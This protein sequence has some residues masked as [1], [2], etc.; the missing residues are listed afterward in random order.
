MAWVN[1]FHEEA[2]KPNIVEK[3]GIYQLKIN[4][5]T[6]DKI[7]AKGNEPEK[8][9]FKADCIINA[10][11]FPHVSVFLT[12]GRNFNAHATAFFDTFQIPYGDF[13]SQDW[14]GHVGWMQILLKKNGEYLNMEPRYILDDN[15]RVMKPAPAQPQVQSAPQNPPSPP[16]FNDS[17]IIF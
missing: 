6:T 2:I 5:V 1:D 14:I 3:E 10:P 11:G 13:N 7:P 17:E 16:A 9:Y 12:E 8:K 4:E 15:G